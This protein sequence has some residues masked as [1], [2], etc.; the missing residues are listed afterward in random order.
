MPPQSRRQKKFWGEIEK[1][2]MTAAIAIAAHSI[3]QNGVEIF[4]ST[5]K[6]LYHFNTTFLFFYFKTRRNL[7]LFCEAEIVIVLSF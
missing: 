6:K 4:H 5:D 2:F 7:S 3:S 1:K